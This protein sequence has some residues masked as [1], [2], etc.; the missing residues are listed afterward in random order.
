M[1]T[2]LNF[3]P[4]FLAQDNCLNFESEN[5]TTGRIWFGGSTS[6]LLL[7]GM[8][9]HRISGETFSAG[10]R[11]SKHVEHSEPKRGFWTEGRQPADTVPVRMAGSAG[12]ARFAGAIHLRDGMLPDQ[13]LSS[14]SDAFGLVLQ[15]RR[16]PPSFRPGSFSW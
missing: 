2:L 12:E 6:S 13:R 16:R 3:F 15:T 8:L 7:N 14:L 1:L 4:L 9:R 11:A 5:E 10:I